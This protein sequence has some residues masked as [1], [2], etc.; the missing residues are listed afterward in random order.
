MRVIFDTDIGDDIDDAFA[1]ALLTRLPEVSLEAVTTVHGAVSARARLA[2]KMLAAAGRGQIPVYLG[3]VGEG[4]P[5]GTPAYAAWAEDWR[6]TQ[7]AQGG[8]AQ[9]ILS[10]LTAEP[11]GTF[12]LVAVGPLSNVAMVLRQE[13]GVAERLRRLVIMGGSVRVGYQPDSPPCP[14][15]NIRSDPQAAQVVLSSGASLLVVPLDATMMLQPSRGQLDALA[16]SSDVLARALHECLRLWGR[17]TPTLFDPMAVACALEE[18]AASGK[19]SLPGQRRFVVTERLHLEVTPEGLTL[20]RPD[21]PPNAE[22]ATGAKPQ[23]FLD[24]YFR[25][26]LR[27]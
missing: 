6:E 4:E 2:L 15:Y 10:R 11:A 17:G 24:W 25:R 21:L 23:E 1:L 7:I 18:P 9:F 5:S 12:T 3:A 14:E 13:P 16:A 22:V 20:E 19:A 27:G 26:L 8:A